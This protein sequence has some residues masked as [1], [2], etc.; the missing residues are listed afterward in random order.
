M[1]LFS[2]SWNISLVDRTTLN[3]ILHSEQKQELNAVSL[4][5]KLISGR[6][7]CDFLGV[8]IGHT[9]LVMYFVHLFCFLGL[10]VIFILQSALLVTLLTITA[11][12]S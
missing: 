9:K 10:C 1:A 2:F 12:I 6:L 7:K 5:L 11:C 4:S 3:H 8:F